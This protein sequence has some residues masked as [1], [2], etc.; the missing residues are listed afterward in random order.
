MGLAPDSGADHVDRVVCR[1]SHFFVSGI[2]ADPGNDAGF[3]A[4][5]F[6]GLHRH[7]YFAALYDWLN[8]EF[9][10]ALG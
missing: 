3:C 5:D 8:D 6:G 10:D 7:G 1:A 2:D 4:Q 9:Y